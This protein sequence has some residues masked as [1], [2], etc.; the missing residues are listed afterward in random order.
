[1]RHRLEEAGVTQP[2]DR[3]RSIPA[4]IADLPG[5]EEAYVDE[6]VGNSW[7]SSAGP[8][9]E[10][11]ERAFAEACSTCSSVAVAVADG[12]IALKLALLALG[13]RPGD[14]VMAPAPY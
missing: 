1:M 11:F 8:F 6:A 4:A 14:E 12:T 5:N 2:V 13:V 9:A 10:R 7:V 3:K